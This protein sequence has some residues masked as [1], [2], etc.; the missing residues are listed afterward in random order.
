[1]GNLFD[2]WWCDKRE[3]TDDLSAWNT[4][5][6]TSMRSMFDGRTGWE[7]FDMSGWRTSKVTDMSNMFYDCKN[8]ALT[9]LSNWDV[10]KVT[11]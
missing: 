6:V 11:T 9:G 2:I 8:A 4:K 1:M 5:R 3:L 10:S 7:G